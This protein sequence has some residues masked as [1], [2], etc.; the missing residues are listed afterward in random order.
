VIAIIHTNR[1]SLIPHLNMYFKSYVSSNVR[2]IRINSADDIN[3]YRNDIINGKIEYFVFSNGTDSIDQDIKGKILKI[4]PNQK[5]IFSENGWLT[6]QDFL[7]LDFHGIGNNSDVYTMTHETLPDVKVP[8]SLR[9]FVN[10]AV[11]RRL[12]VG[13]V[14]NLSNYVLV[15]LQ[16]NNDSKL[17]IG[18]PYFSKVEQFVDY[19][20]RMI[21]PDIKI[22]FKNHPDNKNRIDIPKLPNVV[23][24]TDSGYSKSSLIKGSLFVAG[25]NS[26]FLIESIY[27]NHKTVAF[28]LDLFSNKGI[29]IEGYGKSFKDI[30]DAK[31][32]VKANERFINTLVSKQIP[33]THIIREYK[34]ITDNEKFTTPCCTIT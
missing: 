29:V 32:N 6:W 30:I 12:S 17:I 25:I 11:T 4:N 14:C 3:S 20:I 27:M 18:S 22:L 10:D 15:P 2:V 34:K 1:K 26:T 8:S 33:K 24:I 13:K 21:P 31:L 16:V 5:L 23:D 19:M 7:Y 28:G 9:S